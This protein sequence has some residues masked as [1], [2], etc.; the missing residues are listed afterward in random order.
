VK[1]TFLPRNDQAIPSILP[2]LGRADSGVI[3]LVLD[4]V[5]RLAF[6]KALG[7]EGVEEKGK[8]EKYLEHVWEKNT[9]IFEIQFWVKFMINKMLY[10]D[11]EIPDILL[12]GARKIPE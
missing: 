3:R 10:P 9:F 6:E 7:R 8:K 11:M 2:E 12:P 5:G 4:S 1:K